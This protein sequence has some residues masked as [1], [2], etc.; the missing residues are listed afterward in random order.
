MVVGL[1]SGWALR[2]RGRTGM[3]LI[4]A[5]VSWVLGSWMS[6]YRRRMRILRR[7]VML[8]S[9]WPMMIFWPRVAPWVSCRLAVMFFDHNRPGPGAIDLLWWWWV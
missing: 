3:L 8:L 5:R 6:C 9:I 1:R 2:Y 7:L 4:L